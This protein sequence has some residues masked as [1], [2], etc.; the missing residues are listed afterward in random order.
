MKDK[1]FLIVTDDR[2]TY[3]KVTQWAKIKK[4]DVKSFRD[5]LQFILDSCNT[6][7]VYMIID[8]EKQL[9]YSRAKHDNNV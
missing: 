6:P 7:E 4:S 8:E 2:A 3:G 5:V 9:V 1:N